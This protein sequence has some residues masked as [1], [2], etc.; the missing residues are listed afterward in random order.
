MQHINHNNNENNSLNDT[1][2]NINNLST[3]S[4]ATST[5]KT[6]R[7]PPFLLSVSEMKRESQSLPPQTPHATQLTSLPLPTLI[8]R[9]RYSPPVFMPKSHVYPASVDSIYSDHSDDSKASPVSSPNL[10]WRES[11]RKQLLP[12]LH[13]RAGRTPP[14]VSAEADLLSSIYQRN[15]HYRTTTISS[16]SPVV[17]SR[18]DY[19]VSDYPWAGSS[20]SKARY[21]PPFTTQ[22]HPRSH[23]SQS[24]FLSDSHR[25][26]QREYAIRESLLDLQRRR[27][28]YL[29]AASSSYG[30]SIPNGFYEK[31]E[32][33]G[34]TTATTPIPPVS[35]NRFVPVAVR[36]PLYPHVPANN[37]RKMT[38]FNPDDEELLRKKSKFNI[39][40]LLGLEDKSMVIP[41]NTH[42]PLTSP[43]KYERT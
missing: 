1:K 9:E 28:D 4:T 25:L 3:S 30:S 27:S 20:S 26:H 29:H 11:N 36:D 35:R 40:S 31:R 37:K 2:N 42:R 34:T 18:N 7:E 23:S 33:R 32:I 6:L 22:Y 10:Q 38:L 14:L 43:R 19:D 12:P 21:S 24:G 5:K 41:E 15:P 39:S 8:K 17:R 13:P 16:P